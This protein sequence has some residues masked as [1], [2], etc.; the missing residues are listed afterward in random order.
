[1]GVELMSLDQA[2]AEFKA[3]VDLA[4]AGKVWTL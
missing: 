3:T 2:R 4:A 1:M